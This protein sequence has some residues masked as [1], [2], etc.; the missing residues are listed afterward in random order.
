[1]FRKA[2]LL[3]TLLALTGS[4][5][6]AQG[7]TSSGDGDDCTPKWEVSDGPNDPCSETKPT[8]TCAIGQMDA[9]SSASGAKAN[10]SVS[11]YEGGPLCSV[12]NQ[13]ACA[14][15]RS[16]NYTFV[17]PCNKHCPSASA[18]GLSS[19]SATVDA[20]Y[21]ICAGAHS[22]ALVY[23]VGEVKCTLWDLA[24]TCICTLEAAK[25]SDSNWTYL[26]TIKINGVPVSISV[27]VVT[28]SGPVTGHC[29]QQGAGS[30]Q[31]NMFTIIWQTSIFIAGHADGCILDTSEVS[32]SGE[33]KNSTQYT[34]TWTVCDDDDDDG[35]NEVPKEEPK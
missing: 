34:A 18:N 12:E 10:A 22:W 27:P 15:S 3:L 13:S 26:G 19:G 32:G 28:A 14:G 35:G 17:D 21:V 8:T 25:D 30:D 5:A 31:T 4:Q 11:G 2:T 23:G 7:S 9:S 16:W 29:S 20:E 1:M 24:E 6:F 33:L